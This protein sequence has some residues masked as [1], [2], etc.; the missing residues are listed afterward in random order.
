MCLARRSREDDLSLNSPAIK[1]LSSLQTPT[2][3]S[4]T[5]MECKVIQGVI[6]PA[7]HGMALEVK[8]G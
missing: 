3:R 6:I 8:N 5:D 7:E 2:P 1:I 4:S